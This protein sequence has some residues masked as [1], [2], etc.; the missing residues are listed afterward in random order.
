MIVGE[1]KFGYK[2]LNFELF[3]RDDCD[4]QMN[5]KS[6]VLDPALKTDMILECEVK[7]CAYA[8]EDYVL[9]LSDYTTTEGDLMDMVGNETNENMCDLI[10]N[11][12][13][14]MDFENPT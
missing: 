5:M 10:Q 7:W 9:E 12:C 14:G 8:Y 4:W 13:N 11:T 2:E 1:S 6:F 3:R